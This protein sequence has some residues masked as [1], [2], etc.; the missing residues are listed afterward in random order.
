MSAPASLSPLTTTQATVE[1]SVDYWDENHKA[2]LAKYSIAPQLP[3]VAG[4]SLAVSTDDLLA[5]CLF[6]RQQPSRPEYGTFRDC[7]SH[8]SQAQS[9]LDG[10]IDFNGSSVSVPA[11]SQ[12]PPIDIRERLG[13]AVGL[14]VADKL[15]GLNGADWE[16]IPQQYGRHAQPTNDWKIAATPAVLVEL[17]TK[18]SFETDNMD[19]TGLG[20]HVTSIAAK[21][22]AY[23]ADKTKPS[24][25][26]LGTIAVVGHGAAQPVK[27]WLLD[28]P[29]T[30]EG[31]EPRQF[32]L[33]AR[34]RFLRDWITF[35]GPRSTLAAVLA[36]RV[37]VLEAL[38]DPFA[39]DGVPLRSSSGEPMKLFTISGSDQPTWFSGKSRIAGGGGVL[40]PWNEE[41]MLLAGFRDSL[42]TRA[43]EQTFA[44]IL[45][46]QEN[47]STQ[48][49]RV[50]CS[51]SDSRFRSLEGEKWMTDARQD[52][53]GYWQF[54]RSCNVHFTSAG[55]AFGWVRK[56]EGNE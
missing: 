28:P 43:A 20:H 21:K 2:D 46:F 5:Y 13:E 8:R 19:Q 49:R 9:W 14:C 42:L 23:R 15:Y 16:K 47:A 39:L 37:A 36:D 12:G 40:V 53:R 1:I 38:T 3:K 45:T 11:S 22:A 29:A 51:L 4:Q 17:E 41:Y 34:M 50:A 52:A 44:D 30:I 33:M 6:Y 54:S 35:V 7:Y 25:E 56:Q 10:E 32:K 24:A 48:R 55:L 18:G 26:L 31:I 27:C